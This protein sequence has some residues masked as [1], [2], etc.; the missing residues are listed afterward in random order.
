MCL[1]NN[2]IQWFLNNR[3]PYIGICVNKTTIGGLLNKR[4]RK[5]IKIDCFLIWEKPREYEDAI[6]ITVFI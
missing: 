4:N 3:Y 2:T 6:K 5:H 1:L